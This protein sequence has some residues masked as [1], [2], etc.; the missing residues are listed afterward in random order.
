MDDLSKQLAQ[1]LYQ[2]ANGVTKGV[3][4]AVADVSAEML[5][6][7][8]ADAPRRNGKY[9]REM[10]LK[11]TENSPFALSKVWHGGQ[12]Y[13]LTHL[14]ENGH[15]RRSGGQV[16]GKPHIR[17][18]EEWAVAEVEKRMKKAVQDAAR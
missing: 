3:K 11:T 16:K 8:K 6:R 14:L 13:R 5:K 9:K 7:I 17:P 2:Y 1:S 4:E 15:A 10:K 18:N 12:S